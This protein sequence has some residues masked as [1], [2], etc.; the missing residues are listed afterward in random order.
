MDQKYIYTPQLTVHGNFVI[1]DN[2]LHL[3]RARMEERL[4]NA[5]NYA[6]VLVP[7]ETPPNM[8][9]LPHDV[10]FIEKHGNCRRLRQ[11]SF[12]EQRTYAEEQRR[13]YLADRQERR[14]RRGH[15]VTAY[16]RSGRRHLLRQAP[17]EQ[18]T[19]ESKEDIMYDEDFTNLGL[20]GD[21]AHYVFS[22]QI[23]HSYWAQRFPNWRDNPIYILNGIQ[24]IIEGWDTS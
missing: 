11:L 16:D 24:Q 17:I 1:K 2:T 19:V 13:N 21:G 12:E 4:W 14:L 7:G 20:F 15:I 10:T 18:D 9:E 5:F 22:E 8:Y 23:L 6:Q 3:G